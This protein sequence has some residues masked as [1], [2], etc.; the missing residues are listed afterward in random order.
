MASC[1]RTLCD[2]KAKKQGFDTGVL[3]A[4]TFTKDPADLLRNQSGR[5]GRGGSGRGYGGRG[6]GRG[7]G[8]RGRGGASDDDAF[9]QFKK[10]M[11]KF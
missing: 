9:F 8:G 6:R 4:A 7:R 2:S 1:T 5:G 11:R 10:R 3:D